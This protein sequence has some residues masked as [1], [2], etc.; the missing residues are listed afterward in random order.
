MAKRI[1]TAASKGCDALDPDNVDGYV[2][3]FSFTEAF[4]RNL[5]PQVV[6]RMLTTQAN[7]NGLGLTQE[8]TVDFI[9]FLSAEARGYNMSIGLKNAGA[10]IDRVKDVVDFAVN[11]Q[12]VQYSECTV[13]SKFIQ[14]GKPVFHIEYPAGAPW[15]NAPAAN[16]IFSRRGKSRGS[17]KFSTVVKKMNLD[18]W[19]RF[20]DG[21]IHNTVLGR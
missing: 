1:K 2:S 4:P 18:G 5:F 10:V 12:C 15:I 7:D 13:F 11:E 8:D 21:S 14:A 9:K 17:D 20:W 6:G 19:V 16:S 3:T